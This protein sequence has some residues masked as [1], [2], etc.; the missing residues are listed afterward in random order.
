MIYE[1]MNLKLI[2]IAIML[3]N[4]RNVI[5]SPFLVSTNLTVT[6]ET[7]SF[8]TKNEENKI[9]VYC[10]KYYSD[11]H[12]LKDENYAITRTTIT[13]LTTSSPEKL[14]MNINY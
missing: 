10:G 3:Y 2:I 9:T 6:D 13:K 12:Y 4:Y 8:K 1:C 5:L 11:V 7:I 14:K